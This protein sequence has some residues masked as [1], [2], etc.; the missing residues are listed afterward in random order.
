MNTP[1]LFQSQALIQIDEGAVLLKHFVADNEV[2]LLVEV[3]E[4]IAVAPP[5]KMQTQG[6]YTMS[7]AMTNTGQVGWVSD[8]KGY[9]YSAVDPHAGSY[10]PDMPALMLQMACDAALQ[11]GYANFLPDACLVNVYQVGAKMALHQDSDERDFSQP[12]VSISLG[13][14]ATFLFGG[15]Q[16]SDKPKKILLE[17]G[18]A[19][20]WGGP[21]RMHF[22][23]VAP[24]KFGNHPLLGQQR[25]NL[26]FRKAL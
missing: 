18:D 1:S 12:I 11:A 22:H 6:G 14:P 21:S 24:L 20:V 16:R 15:L 5:R 3:N 7:V 17:H 13:L 2:A 23:G 4:V 26:T 19:V 10:W 8:R 25:I 9:R